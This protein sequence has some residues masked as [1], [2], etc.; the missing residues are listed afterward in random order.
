MVNRRHI[1]IAALLIV[2][3][4]GAAVWWYWPRDTAKQFSEMTPAERVATIRDRR[5]SPDVDF[6]LAALKDENVDV[7]IMA[8]DRLRGE[9]LPRGAERAAALVEALKDDHPGVRRAVALAL[10]W[11]GPD[12]S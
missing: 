5:G 12:A 3:A 9:T 2:I 6:L 11:I 1:V 4:A 7:R 8:A 10:G